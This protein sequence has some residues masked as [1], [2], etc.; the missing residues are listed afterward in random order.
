MQHHDFDFI[1]D[2]VVV[3][4]GFKI[5]SE[6]FLGFH[7]VQKVD[8]LFTYYF[9]NNKIVKFQTGCSMHE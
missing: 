8:T 4:V 2:L 3:S 5:L 6:R 9:V 1:F 7:K